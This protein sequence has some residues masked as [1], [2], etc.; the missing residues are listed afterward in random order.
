MSTTA[1]L[2]AVGREARRR[3]AHELG[4]EQLLD[5]AEELFSRHG[6][7]DTSLRE[8]AR[9]A[10]F[11][12]GS[13]YSFFAGKDDLYRQVFVR[14][15]DEFLAGLRTVVDAGEDPVPTLHAMVDF[16]VGFFR[17]HP[18]FGRLFLRS[19]TVTLRSI[20]APA[21][22]VTADRHTEAMRLQATVFARGQATPVLQHGDPDVLARLF[23]ALMSTFQSLDPRVLDH[24]PAARERMTVEELHA[25]IDRTFVISDDRP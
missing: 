2:R 3:H 19:A 1:S 5:A 17:T 23:S 6:F 13:V 18:A 24:D 10:E 15:G 8:V 4:R 20:D 21:D 22:A 11:S 12:V 25:L 14:R 7:H 16:E 9:R